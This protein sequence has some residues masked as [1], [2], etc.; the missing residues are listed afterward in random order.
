MQR[1]WMLSLL[2]A[3]WPPDS[4]E[5]GTKPKA[6][7]HHISEGKGT[8]ATICDKIII[9][10]FPLLSIVLSSFRLPVV[11][12]LLFHLCPLAPERESTA[13]LPFFLFSCPPRL[14]PKKVSLIFL[15]LTTLLSPGIP[16]TLS[17]SYLQKCLAQH[18]TSF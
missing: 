7:A 2:M 3:L 12:L 17:A 9:I 18:E 16:Y 4:E 14:S 8:L 6:E 15:F 13:L 1:K 5:R 11:A 10:A